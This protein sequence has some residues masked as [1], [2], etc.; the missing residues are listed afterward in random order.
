MTSDNSTQKSGATQ[1]DQKNNNQNSHHQDGKGDEKKDEGK[2]EHKGLKSTSS[3]KAYVPGNTEQK[4]QDNNNTI[5]Q[6]RD[7]EKSHNVM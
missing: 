4:N 6:G 5:P 3:D 2:Q 7:R 1:D